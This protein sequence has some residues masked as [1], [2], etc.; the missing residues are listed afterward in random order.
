MELA[1]F[2]VVFGSSFGKL[3]IRL[4]IAVAVHLIL[5]E[6]IKVQCA[7]NGRQGFSAAAITCHTE[8]EAHT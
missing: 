4:L 6:T 2:K 3:V 7:F 8:C 1:I 5:R